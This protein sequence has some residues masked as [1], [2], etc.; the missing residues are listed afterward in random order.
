MPSY[1]SSARDLGESS[2]FLD[3]LSARYLNKQIE[4]IINGEAV[5]VWTYG[6]MAYTITPTGR[7]DVYGLEDTSLYQTDIDYISLA[8]NTF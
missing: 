6:N 8:D 3:Y 4:I 1:P 7:L 2:Y 5:S